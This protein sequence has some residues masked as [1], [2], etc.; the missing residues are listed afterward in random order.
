MSVAL[1]GELVTI[2]TQTEWSWLQDLIAVG[3]TAASP[4]DHS[5]LDQWAT[6][7]VSD[8]HLV[9]KEGRKG[10]TVVNEGDGGI[11]NENDAEN[12][13]GDAEE[14]EGHDD[15]SIE[16]EAIVNNVGDIQN[17][18][19]NRLSSE[20]DEHQYQPQAA[21]IGSFKDSIDKYSSSYSDSDSEL[22]SIDS[23]YEGETPFPSVGLPQM[24]E[25]MRE[26][27]SNKITVD[28][29]EAAKSNVNPEKA[30]YKSFF[31]GPC[32]FCGGRV[33]PLPTV[34]EIKT[35]HSSKVKFHFRETFHIIMAYTCFFFAQSY[36]TAFIVFSF[37]YTA[38]I[39]N[40]H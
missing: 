18:D 40:L 7:E 24:L 15:M 13:K 26:T 12:G 22:S 39:S 23:H 30:F 19:T 2:S 37:L 36:I 16:D 21:V 33:L 3:R 34:H 28:L 27:T 8:V 31:S 1:K 32:Q 38:L 25:V 29:K 14:K 35:I 11:E 6:S 20:K 4:L 10:H 5:T 9:P 17:S